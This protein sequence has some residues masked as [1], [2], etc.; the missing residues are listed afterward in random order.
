MITALLNVIF[1][2]LN[3]LLTFIVYIPIALMF[4]LGS[5]RQ[6]QTT[7]LTSKY[8]VDSSRFLITLLDFSYCSRV[9]NVTLLV[10]EN[11]SQSPEV[12][13]CYNK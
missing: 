3:I 8:Q 12:F 6:T 2:V 9:K 11:K 13:I 5:E 1:N 4:C 10:S 7:S